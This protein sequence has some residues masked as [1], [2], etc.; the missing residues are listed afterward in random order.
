MSQPL[1]LNTITLLA[2]V[3]GVDL[4]TATAN[5]LYTVPTGRNAVIAYC[6]IRNVSTSLTTVSFSIGWNS[7]TFN[8]VIADATHTELTGNTLYT[9]LSAKIG[10]TRGVAG[11]VLKLLDNIL[12][13]GAATCT[14]DVYGY[15]Y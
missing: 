3:A 5:T 4:N 1:E 9:I 10:A 6:V 13:G 12:Q 15:L 14:V 11:D 8:N 2:S 7:A